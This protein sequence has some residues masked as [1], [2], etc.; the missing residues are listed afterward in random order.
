MAYAIEV[1]VSVLGCWT[2]L[3]VR[4]YSKFSFQTC[5]N[6]IWRSRGSWRSSDRGRWV[7]PGKS[8]DTA[9]SKYHSWPLGG[10]RSPW[11]WWGA[12][13][14]SQSSPPRWA[15]W[16]RGQSETI[17]EML[18]ATDIENQQ[19]IWAEVFVSWHFVIGI[20]FVRCQSDIWT[21]RRI[22][23]PMAILFSVLSLCSLIQGTSDKR[24]SIRGKR[25]ANSL[26][27][28]KIEKISLMDMVI[29]SG[30]F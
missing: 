30:K 22:V 27:L 11:C 12:G 19:E 1:R 5:H 15:D 6:L 28:D 2:L 29:I 17:S 3:D 9:P 24:L 25:G 18:F 23:W 21:V 26:R 4:C 10:S 7:S 16:S 13:C 8:S 14:P 20:I